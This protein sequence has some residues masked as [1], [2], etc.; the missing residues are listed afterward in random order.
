MTVL[1]IAFAHGV[2]KGFIEGVF[3][4]VAIVAGVVGVIRVANAITNASLFLRVLV[5]I[6]S[7]VIIVALIR[8]LGW[9]LSRAFKVFPLNFA[10]RILGGVLGLMKGALAFWVFLLFYTVVAANGAGRV[11]EAPMSHVL[12]RGGITAVKLLPREWQ[13]III[14]PPRPT[15]GTSPRE[16]ASYPGRVLPGAG[17]NRRVT[18]DVPSV[19]WPA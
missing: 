18:N 1:A 16:A 14:R 5:P 9:L 2:W 17:S 13:K 4:L 3:D 10:N 12:W 6:L 11:A 8:F 15:Q 7:F 19:S